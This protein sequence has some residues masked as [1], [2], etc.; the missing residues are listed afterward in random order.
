[1][2]NVSLLVVWLKTNEFGNIESNL[3]ASFKPN[4]YF[5][6]DI[7]YEPSYPLFFKT[8]W[9][10]TNKNIKIEIKDEKDRLIDL[11]GALTTIIVLLKQ[12]SD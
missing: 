8:N 9:I 2:Y 5:R 3:I 6:K 1:M 4:V 12:S 7:I 10:K 11:A